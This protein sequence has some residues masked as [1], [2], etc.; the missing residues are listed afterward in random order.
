[1]TIIIIIVLPE[2]SA[3]AF[4]VTMDLSRNYMNTNLLTET[5]QAI[6]KIMF[7]MRSSVHFTASLRHTFVIFFFDAN[8]SR[9]QINERAHITPSITHILIFLCQQEMSHVIWSIFLLATNEV[10]LE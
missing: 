9:T 4:N 10:H 3:N 6:H 7:Q 2:T 8:A 5:V 1:M